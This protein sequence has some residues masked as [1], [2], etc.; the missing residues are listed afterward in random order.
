MQS[1][2]RSASPVLRGGPNVV[3]EKGAPNIVVVLMDD[4]G[5]SDL[6]PYGSEIDTPNVDRLA[7]EGIRFTNYHVTP[8]CSPTRAALLTGINPHRAG[9]A[10]PAN[11]DPGYPAYSFELPDNAPTLAESLRAAGYA[12]F[13]VGKWHLT[14]DSAINDAA[15]R[16]SWPLQRGFDRYFGS[17]EGFT[18][19]H[20]PHGLTWDNSPYGVADYP[21]DYFLTDDLTDRAIG[22][23]QSLRSHDSAKPFFLYFAHHAVH[24]PIQGKPEDVE[25]YR[26]AYAVGWDHVREQRFRRQIELGLFGEDTVLPASNSEPGKDVPGW[27]ELTDA[28]RERFAR[29][30]EVYAASVDNVDQNLGRL[31]DSIER[32]GELDNTIVVF[33]SD[34]GGTGEGGRDGTRSYFSHFVHVPGL[35][36]NWDRDVDR[37]VDLIGGPRTAVH[38]PRGW[39]Q[40]SNTPF[41]L[42]KADTFAGGVRAPLVIRWPRGLPR[43]GDGIRRQFGYVTDLGPT[44]LELAGVA[45]LPT[46]NARPAMEPDGASMVDILRDPVAPT[47]HVRQY[48]ETMGNRS[49]ISGRWKIVTNHQ[50]GKAYDDSEWELYDIESD[51]T[52]TTDLASGL[53]DRLAELAAEWEQEAWRNAVF[54]LNDRSPA[55]FLR[56]RSEDQMSAPVVLFPDPITLERY[57]SARLIQLRD[58]TVTIRLDFRRGDRG[59]LVAHG[60]QGGGYVVYVDDDAVRLTYN[61]YGAVL[62]TDPVPLGLGP[63]D[64]TL[65]A[66]VLPEFRWSIRLATSSG[67]AELESVPQLV[68]MAPFT[69]ISVGEDR[70]DRWTGRSTNANA[71]SRTTGG[72]GTCT[73]TPA[74]PRTTTLA[75]SPGCGPRPHGSTTNRT[76]SGMSQPV[77][78]IDDLH[79]TFSGRTGSSVHAVRGA[80]LAVGEGEIVALV[81]E[82]GSGKSAIANAV[83]GLLPETATVRGS[84]QLPGEDVLGMDER[85]LRGMRGA[86][87]SM[88]FQEPATALNPVQTIGWQIAQGLRAHAKVGRNEARTRAVELLDLVGIPEPDKRVGDY[89]HQLSGGQKQRVV[90]A[91]ALANQ[92]KLVIADEP[93]TAL[94]VTVQ[95]EILRLLRDLR[96][97]LGTAVLLIT[98]NMGVVAD[99]ADRV[100]V[101]RE[102]EVLETAD[103]QELF[104]RPEA[105][106]TREL[107][108]VVPRLDRTSTTRTTDTTSDD[109]STVLDFEDVVV[110][111]AGRFGRTSFRAIPG[112]SLRLRDAEVLGLVG[113]S[114]SGKST[115]ARLAVG[116]IRP[117]RGQAHVLGT[118]I[119]RCS[120][121]ELRRLRRHIGFVFQDPA[122]SLDPRSTVGESIAEPLLV[123]DV[124]KG[125]ELRSRVSELLESVRLPTGFADRRPGELSGGQKQRVGLARALAL[126][127]RL[128]VADEPT[129]AL[130]VSVQTAVLE[131]FD[132]LQRELGFSC[133]FIS[134]D[135]AV[136]DQVA[137]RIA[138]LRAGTVVE[139]GTPDTVL[140]DPSHPYTRTLIDSI[141]IPD[142]EAQRARRTT[143]AVSR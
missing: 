68:G 39:G 14:R 6:S 47:P 13:M 77:I 88:V 72:C 65:T 69:G 134:H 2:V 43:T 131:L 132:E 1:V 126:R 96:D 137:G 40:V 22:M 37:D 66:T 36:E 12:T 82:S 11:S 34:N 124:A 89:P 60:D 17:L 125:V 42:Y 67:V 143:N 58:F 108:S 52:E 78:T 129:S 114:G 10:V 90:I 86:H 113:E 106:Y 28:Q 102:G 121:T 138:V 8:L 9:F 44:L 135:L 92:P 116:L 18:S 87:I 100:V 107:L 62:R 59:V 140:R 79:I 63:L 91:L 7:A 81:G 16:S 70:G 136:V 83:L 99:L 45:H 53:P 50:P 103:V 4:L 127:P 51:P 55:A 38:Y 115:L 139:S 141:P 110:D 93:T 3:H 33:T 104:S 128:L 142:P 130:D 119:A 32:Y 56:R 111:Y 5:F 95:A 19:L 74:S 48:A 24:G 46:R 26:G 85:S 29:Y 105:R 57:R 49:Y 25:K 21:D 76:R 98:H 15:D 30:M 75:R 64:V 84:I 94:D 27:D 23:I 73:T 118:D 109:T 35:P 133:L 120:H 41:R 61:A 20:A 97:R 101:L 31:L 71:A 122:A 80:N 117:V 123:H 54:P 112:V